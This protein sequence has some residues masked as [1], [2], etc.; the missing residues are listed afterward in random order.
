MSAIRSL[1]LPNPPQ[2]LRAYRSQLEILHAPELFPYQHMLLRAWE[3]MRLSSVFTVDGIPTV[4]VRDEDLPLN[5]A[6]AAEAHRR[7]WNQG[8][9]TILLVRDPHFVRV[10]S[11]MTPPVNPET[12]TEEEIEH[13]LVEKLDLASQTSWAE[14]FYVQLGNGH[15]Y[16]A[17][18][19]S[20]FDPQQ[21]VDAFLL[22]NLSFVR[23]QLVQGGLEPSV[24]HSFLGRLLFTCYL[25]DRGIIE[26]ANYFPNASWRH[27]H[28]LLEAIS[29]PRSALYDTLFPAL[30][31]DFNGSMFDDE[32]SAEK[33]RIEPAHFGA[34]RSFLHG[35]D[36]AAGRG[37]R[38]LGFWAYDFKFIPV[39]TISAIYENFLEKEGDQEKR[40]AGAFYTPRFLA[41]MALDLALDGV[42]PLYRQDRYFI[43]PACGSGIF[44]VLLFNRL[45]AEWS[46]AQDTEVS[47]QERAEALLDRLDMLVGVDKNLT[48]CRIACFSLYL[49]FLDQFDPPDVRAYKLSTGKKLPDILRYREAKRAPEHS[50]V[51]EAD[52]FD[53]AP[54]L[55]GRFDLVIGNPPWA[56][57][58]TKQ[59]ANRFMEEAPRLLKPSGRASLLLPSKVFLNQTDA[60]QARWLR[61]V[62]LE[63]LIQLA[64]YRFILFKEALCPC[65]IAL[66]SPAPPDERNHQIEL[67][68]PKVSRLDLRDGVIPVS[69]QDRKW[70]PL[71]LVL[72]ATEQ[73]A[74]SVAWKSHLW[75]TP[76]DLK[77]LDFLFSLP[78]LGD[79]VGTPTQVSKGTKRWCKG[80]G[81]QPLR[82]SS[83]IDNPKTMKWPTSDPL[84][85]P[86]L[87]DDLF[88][89]PLNMT[90]RLGKYL[91]S[92]RYRLDKLHRVRSDRIYKP[93]LVLFNQG[94][95]TA[96]FF[97]YRVRFQH[98]LQSIAGPATDT[99]YL[100]WL[101]VVLRSKFARYFAFHTAANLGTERD[102]V[103]LPEVLRMPF[104]LPEDDCASTKSS[105]I[106]RKSVALLKKQKDEIESA[107]EVFIKGQG[108]RQLGP[109]FS[110]AVS[111]TR[112][113]WFTRQKN[114][115]R[116]LQ[117]KLDLLVYEYYGLTD[118]EQALIEDTCNITDKSD[119]PASLDAARDIPTLQPIIDSELE[120]YC[121]MLVEILN[122]WRSGRLLTKAAGGVDTEL[123]LGLVELTQANSPKQFQPL[124]VSQ[125]ISAAFKRLHAA[126]STTSNP[127]RFQRDG[128]VF[129]GPRI[130]LVKPAVRGR[131]TRTEALNDAVE[132]RAQIAEA[133]QLA[134]SE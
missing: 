118:Q 133:Q 32:L 27:L 84:V 26:L 95:T 66:F 61:Q 40:D 108:T 65:N 62:T 113:E 121:T 49:A 53:L 102:K 51:R 120:P 96:A 29:D 58:G 123:G 107:A 132:I 91:S 24:A 100:L 28:E 126:N 82:A 106:V 111:E 128:L 93:P 122:G 44:L 76:R 31:R 47:P 124:H 69:P 25:C 72:D 119:T 16:A 89:V 75:G 87:I 77:F 42:Y 14:S 41:E 103:H 125:L 67:V 21:S 59:L 45:A 64:D 117:N 36:L 56:G 114:K 134:A 13:R 115:A 73:K 18:R 17:D 54:K 79:I 112:N 4:Y 81:F 116:E 98:S 130:Y 12:A 71:R 6:T 97:D 74:A 127:F 57:R 35:D 129:D 88:F 37:Q 46:A 5:P 3:E 86:E 52:F 78:R 83:R 19:G 2:G 55:R 11:S 15:Y 50:I 92:K 34:I 90:Y 70:L 63:K 43:D 38:S 68:V 30:K 109:L 10:F 85:T 9:A 22:R 101:T 23:D 104:F 48:A 7:F 1:P 94:F 80:Q 60:F 20:K 131:W 33:A 110:S 39:E 105:S 8:I 99:D